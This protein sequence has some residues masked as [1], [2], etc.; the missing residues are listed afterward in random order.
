MDTVYIDATD[1]PK[2]CIFLQAAKILKSGGLVAVPTETVYGLAALGMD[3]TAVSK[4]YEV[5]G[6]PAQKPISL[7]VYDTEAFSLCDSVPESAYKLAEKFWPGPLT[8]VLKRKSIIPDIVAAGGET[9][10]LRCPRHP[11]TLGIIKAVGAPLAA[12]SANMSGEPSPKSAKD[13]MNALQGRIEAV[14]DGGNCDL[15]IESTIIDL[16]GDTPRI[17]RQGGLPAEDIWNVIEEV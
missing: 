1:K 14:V 4:I 5:K 2:E 17:L 12:P 11:I 15:G 3:A 6:R 9:V 8:I 10:G 16:S 13:T 7:L